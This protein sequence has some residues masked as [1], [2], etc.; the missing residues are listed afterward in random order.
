MECVARGRA[1]QG[2]GCQTDHRSDGHQDVPAQDAALQK[3]RLCS[4][5][6]DCGIQNHRIPTIWSPAK[7]RDLGS[8]GRK[9]VA[10]P[11]KEHAT[12]HGEGAK[13]QHRIQT[14]PERE[15]DSRLLSAQSIHCRRYHHAGHVREHADHEAGRRQK[16]GRHPKGEWSVAFHCQRR[17][18]PAEEHT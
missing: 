9:T 17:S 15:R 12:D 18:L 5:Q 16:Q 10:Q 8:G 14:V 7:R 11:I 3:T 13:R 2:E 4:R 1:Y 6:G